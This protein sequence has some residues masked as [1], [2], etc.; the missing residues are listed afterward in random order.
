MM[1]RGSS[2]LHLARR[3]SP[4]RA[5]RGIVL[6]ETGQSVVMDYPREDLSE[7]RLGEVR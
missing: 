4:L 5:E 2:T 6:M 3:F 1:L 7:V